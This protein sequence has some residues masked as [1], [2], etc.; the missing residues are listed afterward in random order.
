M[1]TKM[2]MLTPARPWG[3]AGA[4]PTGVAPQPA[5]GGGSGPALPASDTGG[6]RGVSPACTQGLYGAHGSQSTFADRGSLQNHVNANASVTESR[7]TRRVPGFT[8]WGRVCA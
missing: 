7:W 6:L 2:H 4:A 8:D 5:P 3:R 1:L